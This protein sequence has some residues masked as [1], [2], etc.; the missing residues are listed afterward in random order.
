MCPDFIPLHV[1][2]IEIDSK[3]H[4]HRLLPFGSITTSSKFSMHAHL[5]TLVNVKPPFFFLSLIR[6]VMHANKANIRIDMLRFRKGQISQ[7]N[8]QLFS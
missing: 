6:S 2:R 7:P 3:Y 8:Q 4:M 1:I 5:Y